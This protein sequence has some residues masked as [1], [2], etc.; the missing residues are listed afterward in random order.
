[1]HLDLLGDLD[2]LRAVAVPSEKKWTAIRNSDFL[3]VFD[4]DVI[5]IADSTISLSSTIN[6]C[7]GLVPCFLFIR[8]SKNSY[9]ARSKGSSF[10]CFA[11]SG[12]T[13]LYFSSISFVCDSSASSQSFA[14]I[15]GSKISMLDISIQGCS[16]DADGAIIHAM[17]DSL[18]SFQSSKVQNIHSNGFGG[19]IFAVSSTV[20]VVE[21]YFYNC[22]SDLG[23]G[24]IYVSEANES[25][26][27]IISA[28]LKIASSIFQGC[29]TLGNG[30]A[31]L[32]FLATQPTNTRF[33]INATSFLKC[34]ASQGGALQLIGPSLITEVS[35]SSFRQCKA[36]TMGGAVSVGQASEFSVT[37]SI[38]QNNTAVGQGGGAIRLHNSKFL[39]W[40]T[41]F[42]G[43]NAPN[44]GGGVIFWEGQ[45]SPA[46]HSHCPGNMQD[47]QTVCVVLTEGSNC[48]WITC[49]ETSDQKRKLSAS[50]DTTQNSDISEQNVVDGFPSR[51]L[52]GSGNSIASHSSFCG[53]GNT[54]FFGSCVATDGKRIVVLQSPENHYVYPGLPFVIVVAKVDAYDQVMASDSTSILDI[55][56]SLNGD[57]VQS[58][59]NIFIS[60]TSA[61][62]VAGVATFSVALKAVLGPV[63]SVSNWSSVSRMAYLTVTGVGAQSSAPLYSATLSLQTAD[64]GQLCPKGY[65][66]EVEPS[67]EPNTTAVNLGV[68]SFCGPG[69]YSLYPLAPVHPN[70]K[71]HCLKCPVGANCFHG[72]AVV[73]FTA[74]TWITEN[75][76]YLLVSCPGGTQLINST[77]GTSQGQ[78]SHDLQQCKKCLPWQYIIN[79]NL[80]TC[81]NCTAGGRSF[82]I[83]CKFG[84]NFIVHKQ[85]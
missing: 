39:V 83:C 50:L 17:D 3:N 10:T 85:I 41:L 13:G 70:S 7:V 57:L 1:M 75:W 65:I 36:K 23:G 40:D 37:S 14:I 12:C 66:W 62:L 69:T 34:Q 68:C 61:R 56:S 21:S 27:R 77:N 54:A 53:A 28:S 46:V 26:D 2:D 30:G 47:I 11:S 22:T 60:N 15:K 74:G 9:I 73:E 82:D 5:V 25:R 4:W 43:N 16:A 84:T 72:G 71:P 80:D 42:Q 55:F 35:E 19:V 67:L 81:R 33:N 79:P 64:E 76:E 6:L 18:V 58:P 63:D 31:V 44:G 38:F 45:V 29:Q 49:L 59:Y 51:V 24:A 78:F 20:I 48:S 8:G 32:G 52:Q